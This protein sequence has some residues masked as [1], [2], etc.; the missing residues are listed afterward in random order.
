MASLET[1]KEPERGAEGLPI[2]STSFP[3]SLWIHDTARRNFPKYPQLVL[4]RGSVS[5]VGGVC[6]VCRRWEVREGD[7]VIH[8]V[9]DW[10]I[11]FVRNADGGK[12]GEVGR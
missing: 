9:I 8:D 1:S 12:G 6:G 3:N 2:T 4:S 11:T 7:D 10:K 5:A